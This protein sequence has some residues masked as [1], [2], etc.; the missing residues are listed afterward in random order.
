MKPSRSK[1]S[2]KRMARA[3]LS[4][5][6]SNAS[7]SVSESID[8]VGG[9]TRSNP[10]LQ[11]FPVDHVNGTLEQASD[12]IFQTSVVE[13]RADNRGVEVNENVNVAVGSLLVTRDGAEQG[14]V[15]HAMRPQ[16]GLALLQR[17]YD[18]FAL[19]GA[20]HTTKAVP[21]LAIRLACR[22]LGSGNRRTQAVVAPM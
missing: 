22:S 11:G 19:H 12:V 16:V 7:R 2:T 10:G 13:D 21:M 1:P 9:R 6:S 8:R 15:R 3:M 14:G 18:L 17:P 5:M 20:V 4:R